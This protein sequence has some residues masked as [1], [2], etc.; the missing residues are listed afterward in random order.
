[1]NQIYH[2]NYK[3]YDS[4]VRSAAVN[5]VLMA[6]PAVND[7]QNILLSLPYLKSGELANF[8]M[9]RVLDLIKTNHP[10]R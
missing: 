2:Q 4:T 6:H 1:M 9:A 3:K 10:S 8:V 5:L 7:I